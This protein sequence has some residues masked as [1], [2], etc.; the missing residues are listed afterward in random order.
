MVQIFQTTFYNI[1]VN[2]KLKVCEVS[3]I[4]Q[5]LA[6][7][8]EPHIFNFSKI[9]KINHKWGFRITNPLLQIL[10]LNCQYLGC[11]SF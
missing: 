7:K 9:L 3:F 8:N 2:Q 6:S 4:V 1:P 11:K 5:N 10:F